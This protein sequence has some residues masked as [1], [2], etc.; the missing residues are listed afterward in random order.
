M[1]AHTE[2]L[3]L[4][5]IGAALA[6]TVLLEQAIDTATDQLAEQK[7]GRVEGIAEQDIV[8][9]KGIEHLAQQRLLVAALAFAGTH[10]G[11]EQGPAAQAQQRH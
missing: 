7:I 3:T 10:C 5:E 8:A 6:P 1:I 9:L 2:L 11:I 4:A